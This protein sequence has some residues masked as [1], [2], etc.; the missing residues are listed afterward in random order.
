MMKLEIYLR[1]AWFWVGNQL[2]I[3]INY[4]EYKETAEAYVFDNTCVWKD[5]EMIV[6]DCREQQKLEKSKN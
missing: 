2:P 6:E 1:Q 3:T 4:L 5:V